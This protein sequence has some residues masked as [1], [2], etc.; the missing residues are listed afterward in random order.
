MEHK[1]K[2]VREEAKALIVE[3]HRWIGAA[4]KAQLSSLKPV[5]VGTYRHGTHDT[6]GTYDTVLWESLWV[7]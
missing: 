5:Q 1:D 4:I 6:H 3:L 2:T 7:Y